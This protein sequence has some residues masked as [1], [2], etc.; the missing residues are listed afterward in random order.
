MNNL[1]NISKSCLTKQIFSL[2]K[3]PIIKNVYRTF[4]PK[5]TRNSIEVYVDRKQQNYT[6]NK[7]KEFI[8]YYFN[9][10]LLK[11]NLSPIQ[12]ELVNKKIIWQ[13]WGQ[14]VDKC[15][16]IVTKCFKSVD[17][18][19]NDYQVIR[20][21]DSNLFDYLNLP[22]FIYEKHKNKEFRPAFFSDLIRLALLDVY[23]GIWLDATI[24]LTDFIPGK[25]TNMDYFMYQRDHLASNKE[26]W[27]K[28]DPL[29]FDWDK[30]HKVNVLNSIIISKPKNIVIHTILDLLLNYWATQNQV[31][32]YFFFQILYE[33]LI[34]GKL[35]QFKCEIID[36]TLPHLLQTMLNDSFD[37]GNFKKIIEKSSIHKLRYKEDMSS[38]T[39]YTYIMKKL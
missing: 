16:D 25:I 24:L 14:G 8:E 18:F 3:K 2:T 5:K 7:F 11:F 26:M 33:E 1:R 29:Y 4:V 19:K 34:T 9:T 21:D 12:P 22:E 38:N 27:I 35:I 15:P 30:K 37:Q 17:E 32:H 36:D 10:R 31:P 23:G 39:Y 20:L 13:Y 6:S 28:Y